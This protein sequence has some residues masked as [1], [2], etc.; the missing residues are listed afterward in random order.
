MNITNWC[1]LLLA[2]GIFP[3]GTD[4]ILRIA[5]SL[6]SLCT[7]LSCLTH[8][9]YFKVSSLTMQF[10]LKYTFSDWQFIKKEKCSFKKKQN[11]EKQNNLPAVQEH[12]WHYPFSQI[13]VVH[14]LLIF[15]SGHS[16]HVNEER[17]IK[18]WTQTKA[19]LIIQV[20]K[21]CIPKK[22][23]RWWRMFLQVQDI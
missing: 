2:R 18:I 22:L 10:S 23:S 14:H 21:I 12:W 9:P 8:N 7:I 5:C 15:E 4:F 1:F 13:Y 19:A 11:P 20:N 16:W 17:E 3:V 6:E